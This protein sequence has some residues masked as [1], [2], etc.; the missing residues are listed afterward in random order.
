MCI[1][2]RI[3]SNVFIDVLIGSDIV[4]IKKLI[5]A[6]YIGLRLNHTICKNLVIHFIILKLST[7]I[8][9]TLLLQNTTKYITQSILHKKEN[10]KT[11]NRVW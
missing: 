1:R 6:Y 5:Y 10:V 3:Q 2:D 11:A 8:M 9:I 7:I 4:C